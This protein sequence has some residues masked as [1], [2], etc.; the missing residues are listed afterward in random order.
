VRGCTS[1]EGGAR[2]PPRAKTE[3]SPRTE[4]V[5]SKRTIEVVFVLETSLEEPCVEGDVDHPRRRRA[6]RDAFVRASD[7]DLQKDERDRTD[8]G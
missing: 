4:P 2:I 8:P 3:S 1:R 6:T 5:L 7:A